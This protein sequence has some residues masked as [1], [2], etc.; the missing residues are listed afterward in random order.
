MKKHQRKMLDKESKDGEVGKLKERIKRLERENSQLRS[1][2]KTLEGA[3]DKTKKFLKGSMDEFS[4]EEAIEAAKEEKTLKE[5]K[6]E[7]NS[8]CCSKCNGKVRIDRLAFGNM[9]FCLN[10]ECKH[11]ELRRN[12]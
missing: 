1:E 2:I 10:E 11:T 6:K 5:L 4:V 8:E 9:V 7:A 12:K 3:F